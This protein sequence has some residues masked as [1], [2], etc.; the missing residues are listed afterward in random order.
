MTTFNEAIN[1]VAPYLAGLRADSAA[2]ND[3]YITPDDYLAESAVEWARGLGWNYAEIV[4]EPALAVAD[5][6][7]EMNAQPVDDG[8]DYPECVEG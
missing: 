7:S 6:R 4:A 5:A 2:W 3:G 1:A 8:Y